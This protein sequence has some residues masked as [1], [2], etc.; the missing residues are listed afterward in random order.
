MVYAAN[1][2]PLA[3]ERRRGK[4]LRAS[5]EQPT[6][7][8]SW[9]A[10]LFLGANQTSERRARPLAQ[11]LAR[12]APAH[13]RVGHSAHRSRHPNARQPAVKSVTVLYFSLLDVPGLVVWHGGPAPLARM[14]RKQLGRRARSVGTVGLLPGLTTFSFETEEYSDLYSHRVRYGTRRVLIL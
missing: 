1:L 4:T 11:P 2:F 10:G 5:L 9:H 14:Y 12:P 6:P 13:A 3:R 8:K 7:S